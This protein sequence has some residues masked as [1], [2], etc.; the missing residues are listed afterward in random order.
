[1]LAGESWP[2]QVAMLDASQKSGLFK[3]RYFAVAARDGTSNE[4]REYASSDEL[5]TAEP[6]DGGYEVA[7]GSF[8]DGR[9]RILSYSYMDPGGD[10]M[11][12]IGYYFDSDGLTR[13]ATYEFRSFFWDGL[14]VSRVYDVDP[15]CKLTVVSESFLAL[16][17]RKPR[18]RPKDFRMGPPDIACSVKNP[19]IASIVNASNQP[20]HPTPNRSQG[21]RFVAGERRR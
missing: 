5:E 13:R 9:L 7:N 2:A 6:L 12:G 15:S 1:M 14:I 3:H 20:L 16:A 4:W 21:S 11:W 8:Q 19:P 17:D 18:A 10:N